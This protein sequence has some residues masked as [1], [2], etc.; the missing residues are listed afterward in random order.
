[1]ATQPV[2]LGGCGLRST[3]EMRLPSFVGGVEMAL[4]YLV[5]GDHGEQVLCPQLQEVVGTVTGQDRWRGFLAAGSRTA[6]EFSAAWNSLTAEARQLWTALHEEPSGVLAAPVEGAGGSSQDGSTRGKIVQQLEGLRHK[7]LGKALA[8]YPDQNAR[9][10]RAFK[11]IADDKCAGK[12]LLATPSTDLSMSKPVFQEA[13]SAHLCLPSPAIRDGGWVGRQI[14]GGAGVAIDPYGD[15]VMCSNVIPGDTWRKR[16]DTVKQKIVSEA[17]HA[18]VPADCEV[19]GLF[20]DLL[21]AA[22]QQEGGELQ[23]GRARQGKVPDFRFLLPTPD[24]PRTSLAELKVISAGKTWFPAGVEGKGTDKRAN[25][26]ASEYE[27]ALHDLDVRFHGATRRV[28]GQPHP[29]PGPLGARLRAMGGLEQG[30]LVAGPWGDLSSDL[31][32]LLRLF[33]EQR[34]AAMG[35]A[36]GWEG[37]PD[38]LLGKVM[39]EVRRSMSVTVVRA[40][41]SCLL[42]R[43]SQLLPGARAAAQRRQVALH[44]D[45]RRRRERQAFALAHERRGLGQ[46]GRAFVP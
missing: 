39:G 23:W 22:L 46:V 10:A 21:P 28:R 16:H 8:E 14:P 1:M 43:L 29:P 44:L 12:W 24:G 37:D 2:K 20:A 40:Q 9:P 31:H 6:L 3:A 7:L 36:R 5:E 34:C 32:L 45:E 18:G 15:A 19:F 27:G 35:R 38:G 17:A 26:L 41:A 25:K 33:A 42:E 13:L 11:N 4:P 30:Q